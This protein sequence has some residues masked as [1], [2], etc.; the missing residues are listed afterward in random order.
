MTR[1][2]SSQQRMERVTIQCLRQRI[3]LDQQLELI[4]RLQELSIRHLNFVT[5]ALHQDHHG[6]KAEEYFKHEIKNRCVMQEA[7]WKGETPESFTR[8]ERWHVK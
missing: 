5:N 4:A 6:A 7:L 3:H 2:G 8:S 1:F